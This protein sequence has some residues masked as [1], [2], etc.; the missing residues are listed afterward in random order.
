MLVVWTRAPSHLPNRNAVNRRYNN[1]IIFVGFIARRYPYDYEI[2]V[3][4]LH[5]YVLLTGSVIDLFLSG[6]TFDQFH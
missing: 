6:N 4:L 5:I 2:H 3:K 1:V